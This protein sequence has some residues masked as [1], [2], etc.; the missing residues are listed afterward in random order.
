MPSPKFWP[1]WAVIATAVALGL[2]LF[3]V[4]LG[5]VGLVDETPPLFASSARAMVRTGDWLIPQ[6]NGLP[7]YDKPPLVYWLM[8]GFYSLPGHASWDPLGSWAAALPSAL[9]SLGVVV[10]LALVVAWWE[11]RYLPQPQGVWLLAALCFGLSPLVMLWSRIGVSDSL[12]TALVALAM[13]SSWWRL[14]SPRIPWWLCWLALGLATLTKGPVAFLLF[15]L[16]W[17]LFG[18]LQRPGKLILERLRPVPG[19]LLTL[20]V[21]VP[22]FAAA[23]LRE[24]EPFVQSFFGYHNLQ[25]FAEVVNRHQ[26]PWWLYGALLVV[27]SLPWSPL[28]L[29]GLWRALVGRQVS[30][31][32]FAACWLLAVMLLFSFSATKLPSYW[33]P[34]T[35]AAAILAALA[36]AQRDPCTRW[37]LR[38]SAFISFACAIALVFTP[39][40]LA[41][42]RDPD[43]VPLPQLVER[44]ALVPLAVV[45]LLSGSLLVLWW[46][47]PA[48]R[49][50]VFRPMLALQLS[51]LLLVP[52]V[53]WPLLRLGD[54][55]RS[56]PIRVLALQI[57]RLQAFPRPIAMLGVIRPSVHF[58]S[59][60]PVAYE[61]TS[62]QSLVNLNHR[63]QADPRVRVQQDQPRILVL[64]PLSLPESKHWA[65]LLSPLLQRQGRFGMWWLDLQQLGQKAMVLKRRQDLVPT[66][67]LPRPERF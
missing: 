24:G 66:W 33:L 63:L 62:A 60:A 4:D 43:L 44:S 1:I 7:R 40:W 45:L 54:S 5:S 20:V 10:L 50:S 37:A 16:T 2:V 28:L 32:S 14:E 51:W 48:A 38:L 19:V 23:A 13:I 67:Q 52:A 59:E 17:G 18:L 49:C 30:L 46:S 11:R 8:A 27:A 31:A 21:A 3:V 35:P 47:R 12:L 39:F 34:A 15:G 9:A 42:I 26:S 6:V 64:A 58:Y 41:Q 22:W 61:G 56:Q 53:F 36:L 65:P 25:R 55:L 57:R 29:L